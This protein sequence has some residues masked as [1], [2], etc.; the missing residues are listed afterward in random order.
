MAAR[1]P[2]LDKFDHVIVLMMV[3]RSFDNLLGCAYENDA[4]KQFFGRGEPAFRGVAGR[5]DLWNPDDQNPPN[6][7]F[8]AKAP[9]DTPEDMCHPCPDPGEFYQP[10]VNRQ[11]YG[12]DVVPS[13]ITQLP[14]PAPMIG[15]VQD[16]IRAM[17]SQQKVDSIPITP[18]DYRI[19]MNCFPPEALP[20]T[21]GLARAFAV[22]DEW[23]CSVP[24]QTFCNRSF[25]HSAQSHGY[26]NNSD[27]I[28]WMLHNDAPT[29]FD[30]LG[31]ALG[32]DNGW[33]VYWDH[34]DLFS[35]TRLIHPA[36]DNPKYD[37]NFRHFAK[38]CGLKLA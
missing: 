35:L 11:V 36:L 6:K 8:V 22:S 32:A 9:Y 12:E 5:D 23:F 15:F 18:D 37:A 7:I 19:I 20:V 14:V 17:Q 28:K 33:R 3:N 4:P 34:A 16:Y 13:D 31:D 27:Y 25:F 2:N 1:N 30:R 10:H 38:R 24:S 29:I 26:V 21:S